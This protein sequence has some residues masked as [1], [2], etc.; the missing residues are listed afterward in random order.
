M[1]NH[2]HVWWHVQNPASDINIY[3]N[4]SVIFHYTS[5]IFG[6]TSDK[7]MPPKVFL[8]NIRTIE[9]QFMKQA[10]IILISQSIFI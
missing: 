3:P 1:R 4:T 7:N 8:L 10:A 5:V 9:S 6:N 2:K